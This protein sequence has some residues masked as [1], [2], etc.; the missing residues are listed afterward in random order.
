[1][2]YFCLNRNSPMFS[3][4]LFLKNKCFQNKMCT[5]TTLGEFTIR[6]IHVILCEPVNV[7]TESRNFLDA[8]NKTIIPVPIFLPY[9]PCILSAMILC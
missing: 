3:C 5:G 4:I 1:M 9:G 2:F 8:G 7:E 6:L